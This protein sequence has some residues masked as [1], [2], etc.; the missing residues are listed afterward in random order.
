M[1]IPIEN[2]IQ[3]LNLV[4]GVWTDKTD[5]VNSELFS[6]RVYQPNPDDIDIIEVNTDQKILCHPRFLNDNQ[7][8]CLFMVTYD[9]EDVNQ[10]LPLIV[11]AT[12]LNQ[13][14]VT[15]FSFIFFLPI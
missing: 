4:I 10:E 2:S 15:F 11:H 12:S 6:L 5:S 3:D 8:R 13:S 9:D 7:Y 1:K 14:A